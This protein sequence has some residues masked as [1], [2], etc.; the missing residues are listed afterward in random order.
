MIQNSNQTPRLPTPGAD[1]EDW[2]AVLNEY[3]RH[4]HNADGTHN[5]G[6]FSALTFGAKRDG[7]TNDAPAIQSA[8]DAAA[9]HGGVVWLP[10]GPGAYR[11]EQPLT[12]PGHVALKGGYGG[13]RR[14]LRL[15]QESPRG[16]LLHVHTAEDLSLIH[17]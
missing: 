10:P 2:G 7:I 13:M 15:W 11:C 17:I 8:L 14:G 16:S 9:S 1:D 5:F 12:I 3:L 4:E 6:I